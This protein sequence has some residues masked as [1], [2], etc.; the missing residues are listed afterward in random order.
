VQKYELGAEHPDTVTTIYWLNGSLH[1][2][3]KFQDAS[4]GF[5][6]ILDIQRELYG[7]EHK[8]TLHTQFILNSTLHNKGK[9]AQALQG[10]QVTILFN[11]CDF[12]YRCSEMSSFLLVSMQTKICRVAGNTDD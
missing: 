10:F 4:I 5:E 2:M 8:D 6:N 9:Y 7:A 3:G 12:F 1:K 11:F